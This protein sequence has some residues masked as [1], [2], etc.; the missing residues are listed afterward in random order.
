[1]LISSDIVSREA[2]LSWLG[3]SYL[4]LSALS[5]AAGSVLFRHR[6]PYLSSYW[7][8]VVWQLFFSAV[9]VGMVMAVGEISFRI[10]FTVNVLVVLAFHW[11][12]GSAAAY[13]L[14]SRALVQMPAALAGQYLLLVPVLTV[15]ISWVDGESMSLLGWLG[16]AVLSLGIFFNLGPSSL[17]VDERSRTRFRGAGRAAGVR[18]SGS[19]PG[20][21]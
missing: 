3:L 6:K 9:C 14:W 11:T 10:P 4:F 12:L 8:V 19:P 7:T 16:L 13:W 21:A 18:S 2:N 5:W 1:M 15:L 17:R 20:A